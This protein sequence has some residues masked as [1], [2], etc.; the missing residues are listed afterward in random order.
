MILHAVGVQQLDVVQSDEGLVAP[1]R[2]QLDLEQRPARM[3][4]TEIVLVRKGFLL[5]AIVLLGIG[6]QLEKS[7]GSNE[8]DELRVVEEV[9]ARSFPQIDSV[10]L[11]GREET[12]RLRASGC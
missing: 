6:E 4:G 8:G 2:Q 11:D 7:L 12:R 5:R 9:D 3:R 10:F 1:C